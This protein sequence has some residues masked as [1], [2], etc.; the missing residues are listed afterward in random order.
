MSGKTPDASGKRIVSHTFVLDFLP[1]KQG[2]ANVGGVR[3]LLLTDEEADDFGGDSTSPT[4]GDG[5]KGHVPAEPWRGSRESRPARILH[6]W[7]VVA[8]VWVASGLSDQ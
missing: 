4:T 6:E 5:V 7:A 1:V 8:E 3:L 2:H